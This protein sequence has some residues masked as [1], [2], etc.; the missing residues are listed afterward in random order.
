MGVLKVRVLALL[1]LTLATACSSGPHGTGP[2]PPPSTSSVSTASGRPIGT[3][4]LVLASPA[5]IRECQ[6]AARR[7]DFAVPCPTRVVTDHAQPLSCQRFQSPVPLPLCV[8][9]PRD[10]FVEWIGFDAPRTFVGIDGTPVGHVIIHARP[11]RDSG[12]RPCIGGVRLATFAVL[13][14]TSTIYRCPPDSALVERTARH[15]EGAY[16]GHVLVDWHRNGIDYIVS[17]HGYG[18]ASVTL[19]KNLARSLKLIRP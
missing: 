7:L 17:S 3:V 4:R 12:P 9:L 15:G 10:F 6:L 13:G 8:G 5:F 11:V 14:S 18:A 16:V 19:M 1:V 2:A